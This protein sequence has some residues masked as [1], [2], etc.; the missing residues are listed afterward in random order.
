MCYFSI[1]ITLM[2][3]LI[4]SALNMLSQRFK[5][6]PS[7]KNNINQTRRVLNMEKQLISIE[8]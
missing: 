3:V 5:I 6:L 7:K 4:L 8:N 2:Y 1:V